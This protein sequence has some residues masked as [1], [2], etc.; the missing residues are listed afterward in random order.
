MGSV[1]ISISPIPPVAGQISRDI[2]ALAAS[3]AVVIRHCVSHSDP[4]PP[5]GTCVTSGRVSKANVSRS[6]CLEITPKR[7]ESVH[8]SGG[9]AKT[10]G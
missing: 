10:P 5:P 1:S 6:H 9:H 4:D 2:P 8:S 3:N 7:N